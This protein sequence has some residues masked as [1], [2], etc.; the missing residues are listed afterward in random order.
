M[1]L[2][3]GRTSSHTSSISQYAAIETLTSERKHINQ[4][5]NAFLQRRDLV[6]AELN[7]APGVPCAER[8]ILRSPFLHGRYRQA[9]TESQSDRNRYGFRDVFAPWPLLPGSGFMASP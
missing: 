1:N 6:V 7:Q 5:A 8:R 4:F 9:H 3:Q 2:I